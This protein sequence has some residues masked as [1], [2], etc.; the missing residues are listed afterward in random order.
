[1]FDQTASYA[2][3]YGSDKL[4][5]VKKREKEKFDFLF[6]ENQFHTY[7]QVTRSGELGATFFRGK[8]FVLILSKNGL[9]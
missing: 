6:P 2:S 4:S 8:S 5:I 9:G 7:Y 1:L 3:K